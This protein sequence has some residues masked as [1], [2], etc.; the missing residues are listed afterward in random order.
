M[1]TSIETGPLA[2]ELLREP[3]VVGTGVLEAGFAV[4]LGVVGLAFAAGGASVATGAVGA[5]V[6]TDAAVVAGTVVACGVVV[7]DVVV[8]GAAVAGEVAGTVVA[9]ALAGIEGNTNVGAGVSC[10]FEV[11]GVTASTEAL[12]TNT[13][14]KDLRIRTDFL[15]AGRGKVFTPR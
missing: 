14:N 4:A 12:T 15:C 9:G 7:T 8:T 11:T 6:V 3:K 1:L 13:P 2:W 10:A 5:A